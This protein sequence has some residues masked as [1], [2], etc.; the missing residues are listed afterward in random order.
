[1]HCQAAHVRP[2]VVKQ[3]EPIAT[4][5]VIE[6]ARFVRDVTCE[7]LSAAGYEV[8][9]AECALAARRVFQRHGNRIRLLLCDAVLPDSSGSLLVQSLRRLSSGLKVILVSGYPRGT[10]HGYRDSES[11]NEF[12]AKPYGAA[13]LVSTV[14]MALQKEGAAEHAAQTL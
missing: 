1:M 3:P 4:I 8:L 10:V 6:D 2:V 14:R 9:H 7:I 5:L 13:L 11:G 12:L